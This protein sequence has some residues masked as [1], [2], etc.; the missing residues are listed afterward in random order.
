MKLSERKQLMLVVKGELSGHWLHDSFTARNEVNI[1][2]RSVPS[3]LACLPLDRLSDH[4]RDVS[5]SCSH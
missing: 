1:K 2:S 5:F 4:S 3:R